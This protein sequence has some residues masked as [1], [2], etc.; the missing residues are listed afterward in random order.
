MVPKHKQT[1][2]LSPVILQIFKRE[3]FFYMKKLLSVFLVVAMLGTLAI[4]LSSCLDPKGGVLIF[5]LSDNGEYYI[6]TG[7]KLSGKSIVVPAEYEG[8]P[9][10]KIGDRAFEKCEKLESITISASVQE[11]NASALSF[12]EKLISITVEEGNEVYHSSGNC[13]IATRQKQLVAAGSGFEIPA[14]GSVTVI[15]ASAFARRKKITKVVI[16]ESVTAISYSAFEECTNLTSVTIPYGVTEIGS[17]AFRGC[18]KLAS[19][20]LPGSIIEIH[21]DAFRG[22]KSLSSVT[23]PSSTRAISKGVFADCTSLMSIA[24]HDGNGAYYSEGNCLIE[25]STQRLIAGCNTSVIPY[26]VVSIAESAF[27][28][29]EKLASVHIPG[30]V[31]SIGSE[32]FNGCTSLKS[33][34]IPD[35]VTEIFGYTFGGCTSL[36]SVSIP[37]SVREIGAWAFTACP[38]LKDIKY[39]GTKNQWSSIPKASADIPISAKITCSDGVYTR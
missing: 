31:S 4:G 37:M 1:G 15:G 26:G 33:V 24:V 11:I 14:D 16:P 3:R 25:R 13:L 7:V 30:S 20:S 9:V 23:I 21:N 12:C 32:A 35:G 18:D 10:R 36:T 39:G 28:G 5:E 27:C 6:V 17:N 38:A 19:I 29:C 22:C 34:S 2:S 8:L